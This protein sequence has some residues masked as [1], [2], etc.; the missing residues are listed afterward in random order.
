MTRF[1]QW[2]SGLFGFRRRAEQLRCL[3]AALPAPDWTEDNRRVWSQFLKSD[4]GWVLWQRML[5]VSNDLAQRSCQDSM[6]TAHSAGRAAGFRDAVDW[7]HS[8]SRVSRDTDT[9]ASEATPG[10]DALADRLSP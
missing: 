2:L 7:L 1:V 6:H 9:T 5:A 3:P 10:E 4:V 8:L